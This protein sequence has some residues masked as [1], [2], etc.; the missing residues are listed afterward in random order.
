MP[1]RTQRNATIRA[2]VGERSRV[3]AVP[4]VIVYL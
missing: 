3:A 4:G 2:A 1:V